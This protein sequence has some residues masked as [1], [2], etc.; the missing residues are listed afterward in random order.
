IISS[1]GHETD[2]TLS[3]LVADVRAA[4]PT[5]AAELAVPVLSEIKEIVLEKERQMSYHLRRTIETNRERV[6]RLTDSYI[7]RQ[8]SR[9][10]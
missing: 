7:F 2:T 9:L 10:Y 5:A 8:P 4:T 3:D 6:N 1:V